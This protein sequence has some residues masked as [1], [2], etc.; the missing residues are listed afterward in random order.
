MVVVILKG[1]CELSPEQKRC[2]DKINQR[3][4]PVE[5]NREKYLPFHNDVNKKLLYYDRINFA[6]EIYNVLNN[7]IEDL[8]LVIKN[9]T[10]IQNYERIE[11]AP[12]DVSLNSL[13]DILNENGFESNTEEDKVNVKSGQEYV[14][15][16]IIPEDNLKHIH[17][18]WRIMRNYDGLLANLVMINSNANERLGIGS[19]WRVYP[20]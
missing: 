5:I 3:K 1:D 10:P 8:F 11:V 4:Y 16:K 14:I 15:I 2:V 7:H 19:S 18:N 20:L 13:S 6:R 12:L 9:N 17:L